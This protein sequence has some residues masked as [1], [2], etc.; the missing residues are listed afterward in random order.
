MLNNFFIIELQQKIVNFDRVQEVIPKEF[1]NVL[2]F[3]L[4]NDSINIYF[5]IMMLIEDL[6]CL[7]N[8]Q[9]M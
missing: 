6:K 7:Y 4:Y 1:E 2:I 3:D 9:Y 8:N 5:K